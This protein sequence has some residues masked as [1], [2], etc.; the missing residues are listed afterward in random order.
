MNGRTFVLSG[1]AGSAL[2]WSCAAGDAHAYSEQTHVDMVDLA[3]HVM[4]AVQAH[5]ELADDA[6]PGAEDWDVYIASVAIAPALLRRLQNA[7]PNP[8]RSAA[9]CN[10]SFPYDLRFDMCTI[11]DVQV[12]LSQEY[13]ES[14]QCGV[15][16]ESTYVLQ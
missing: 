8:G 16:D 7:L 4:H 13:G 12:P 11:G 5:P 15:I 1:L 2:A 10:F 6:P 14:D 3:W 9:E